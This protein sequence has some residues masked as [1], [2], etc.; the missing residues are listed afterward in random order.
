VAG[1]LFS[2]PMVFQASQQLASSWTRPRF[3]GF[4]QPDAPSPLKVLH[5]YAS[6]PLL[7]SAKASHAVALLI[8]ALMHQLVCS[9]SL[10]DRPRSVCNE[11]CSCQNL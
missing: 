7:V 8:V 4:P 5:C 6:V 3:A 11:K 9:H 2:L 10:A 1:A